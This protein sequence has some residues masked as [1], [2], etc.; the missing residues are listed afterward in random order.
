MFI[1]KIKAARLS[2][3]FWEISDKFLLFLYNLLQM[4]IVGCLHQTMGKPLTV[5]GATYRICRDCGAYRLYD[6]EKMQFYGE[7]FFRFPASSVN[8]G[9]NLSFAESFLDGRIRRAA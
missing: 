9:Q 5:G 3:I 7:Y 8:T 6:L 1:K 2:K 4:A